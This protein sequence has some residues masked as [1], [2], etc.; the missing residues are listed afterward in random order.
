MFSDYPTFDAVRD[1]CAMCVACPLSAGRNRVVFGAGNPNAA[2]MLIGH[3]PSLTDDRTGLPYSGPAGDLLDTALAQAGLQ[4]SDLWITNLHKCVAT[5]VNRETNR[6]EQRPPKVEEITACAP[7][8]DQELFWV[9]PKAIVAIGG[10]A[11]QVLLGKT[12]QL[13][14]QRGQW[15]DGPHAIPT[16]AIVQ[17]T[18]LKRLSEHDR[19][20]AVEGWREL[21]A[22]LRRAHEFAVQAA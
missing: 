14:E 22:D 6:A 16:L 3:G 4:R 20:K 18:Y 15:F 19:P 1:A 17:P 9:K 5:K 12:F 11:A 7:W 2:L 21:V 10:P 13:T 8:L